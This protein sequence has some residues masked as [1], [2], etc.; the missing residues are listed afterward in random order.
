MTRTTINR[1]GI[2][3]FGGDVAQA[4]GRTY[5]QF[6]Q[7]W[8]RAHSLGITSAMNLS[9]SGAAYSSYIGQLY[10]AQLHVRNILGHCSNRLDDLIVDPVY[11]GFAMHRF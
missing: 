6:A 9:L 11:A 5:R 3:I 7:R 8:P 4:P 1:G 10:M 2:Y